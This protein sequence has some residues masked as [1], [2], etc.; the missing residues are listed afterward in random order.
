MAFTAKGQLEKAAREL[1]QLNEIA[2]EKAPDK[3]KLWEVNL[4]ILQ[5]ASQVLAGELATKQG[6]YEQAIAH[7]KTAIQL[8]DDLKG[9]PPLWYSP[10]RQSLGAILLEV[11]RKAEAE[12]MYREDLK[13]YPN[14]GWSLY[15]LAQSLQVQGKTKEAQ[16]VQ[17]RFEKVWKYA[18]VKL[19]ASRF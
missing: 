6:N 18:D 3:T 17:Q 19:T 1:E 2:A 11:G 13:I 4:K 7:L 9:D 15:G 8:D 10:V 16:E 12:Q 14:N 5:N